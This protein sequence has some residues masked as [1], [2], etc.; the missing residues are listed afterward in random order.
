MLFVL[1]VR[2]RGL[3]VAF[4]N[5]SGAIVSVVTRSGT[6]QLHGSLYEYYFG[7]NV[8][9]ANSW[10]SN[11]TPY[12]NL[13]YT[14]LPSNH[15]SRFGTSIGGPMTP[16]FWGGKTYFFF[17]YEAFRQRGAPGREVSNPFCETAC[18]IL[19]NASQER[20]VRREAVDCSRLLD[21]L[22]SAV[23][24]GENQGRSSRPRP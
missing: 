21:D 19:D 2:P 4:G 3:F 14:P 1:L 6:N 10:K 18:T 7:S 9:A 22:R 20:E 16:R 11:H 15:R 12:G 23:D 13:P 17:N 24:G 8:G 5:A